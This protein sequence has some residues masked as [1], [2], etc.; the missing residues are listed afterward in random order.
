MLT[1]PAEF[2][3]KVTYPPPQAPRSTLPS[4]AEAPGFRFTFSFPCASPPLPSPP[5]P[6]SLLFS[7]P[8]LSLLLTTIPLPYPFHSPLLF[9]ALVVILIISASTR[10][11]T[12]PR[13]SPQL[14]PAGCLTPPA[15]PLLT[16]PAGTGRTSR[17]HRHRRTRRGSSSVSEGVKLAFLSSSTSSWGLR[18]RLLGAAPSLEVCTPLSYQ[19]P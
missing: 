4:S 9:S 8:L 7:L 6:S 1:P 2:R 16:S 13:A 3:S 18:R 19:P 5:F 11:F 17:L 12:S 15:L 10:G 14:V